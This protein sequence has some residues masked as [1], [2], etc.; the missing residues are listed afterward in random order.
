MGPMTANAALDEYLSPTPPRSSSFVA[1]LRDARQATGRDP[2]TG[3]VIEDMNT[4]N[5]LGAIGYL[6]LLDQ[7][8]T[9]V[10]PASAT[11]AHNQSKAIL[12]ALEW[13]APGVTE[14]EGKA[15]Y[16]LRCALAHDYSLFN[17]NNDPDLQHKFRLHRGQRSLIQ[18]PAQPWQGNSDSSSTH[19]QT[20]VS[21]RVLGDSV[22]QVVSEVVKA[23]DR[24]ELQIGNNLQPANMLQRYSF[25]V[26]E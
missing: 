14:K 17:Q 22:E 13:W 3:T 9:A 11:A 24:G 5:W 15:I 21:L 4:G 1:A 20:T 18:L 25:V 12:R 23:H 19:N 2:D 10:Q 8:S 16:A 6:L 26:L 7:I